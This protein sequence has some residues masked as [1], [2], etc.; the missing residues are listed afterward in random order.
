[1][2][3]LDAGLA[4]MRLTTAYYYPPSGRL[5]HREPNAKPEDVWGVSPDEGCVVKLDE[6]AFLKSI[7]RFRKRA[8]PNENGLGKPRESPE[9]NKEAS[10]L[11][12]AHND[13]TLQDDPQLERA[14]QILKAK[15]EG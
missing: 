3:P 7:E 6:A 4:A 15:I 10:G 12:K 13:P 8:D 9:S 1:V 11:A 14:V 5:I 2:I